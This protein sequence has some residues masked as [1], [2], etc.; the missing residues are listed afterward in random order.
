MIIGQRGRCVKA[1]RARVVLDAA[2]LGDRGVE[3]RGHELV[4]L[5]RVVALDEVRRVAVAAEQR[6]QLVAGCAPA[7]SGRRSCSRSGAGSAARRRRA[8]D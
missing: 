2:D 4:H 3:R 7:R 1:V 6:F 8:P 5:H